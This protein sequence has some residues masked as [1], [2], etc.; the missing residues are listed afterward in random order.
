MPA[1]QLIIRIACILICLIACSPCV[2]SGDAEPPLAVKDWVATR[3]RKTAD[4]SNVVLGEF[5][6]T[7]TS[8][9][10]VTDISV[11]ISYQMADGQEVRASEPTQIPKL[12]PRETKDV[13]IATG[14]A[15]NYECYQIRVTYRDGRGEQH[16]RWVGRGEQGQ[17]QLI[18]STP[19]DAEPRVMILG[20]VLWWDKPNTPL[21]GVLRV[22]NV[23]PSS[24]EEVMVKITFDD[25]A[26]QP[27]VVGQ[28]S[29]PLGDGRL[30]VGEEKVVK[31]SVTTAP[32]SYGGYRIEFT[33]SSSPSSAPNE[34]ARWNGGE[35]LG[36]AKV[37]AARWNFERPFSNP[38]SLIISAQLR[39]NLPQ[40]LESSTLRIA[41][42]KG[43]GNEK[44]VVRE[45][46][47]H[48]N[49]EIAAGASRDVSITLKNFKAE[50]DAIERSI[51][52]QPKAV[53]P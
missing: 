5:K 19:R 43:T 8:N 10:D 4:A 48:L 44:R 12:A 27:K 25:G 21:Q 40:A 52:A 18:P 11:V 20:D 29:G 49:D 24:L 39:N 46:F 26:R 33:H 47:I 42:T 50:F 34:F 7:N 35:F 9:A 17:P 6:L 51:Q 37:E 31:L 53:A 16:A 3:V 41:F 30:A 45:V 22:K 23:S 28:W 13:S 15:P 1:H 14:W 32:K 38:D 2:F 36:D